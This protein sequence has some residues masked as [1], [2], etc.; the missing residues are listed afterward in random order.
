MVGG[1]PAQY[2]RI[3]GYCDTY[4]FGCDYCYKYASENAAPNATALLANIPA[5]S[6]VEEGYVLVE[7]PLEK[8]GMVRVLDGYEQKAVFWLG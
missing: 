4:E 6:A 2:R 3:N 1:T 7:N 8:D 5:A